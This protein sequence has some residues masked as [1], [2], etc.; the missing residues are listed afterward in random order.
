MWTY[1]GQN[2]LIDSKI[3]NRIAERISNLYFGLKCQALIEIGPWKGA[4]TKLI[5]QISDNFFVIEK[6][7]TLKAFLFEIWNYLEGDVL[8]INVENILKSRNLNSKKT[9]VVWNLPYYITSPILRKF[10][11]NWS[12]NF[13]GWIFMVQKEVGEKIKSDA[14]KKS[15]L[16]WL[17]NY[18][19]DVDYLKTVSAKAF[20]PAPKVDSCLMKLGM[21]NDKCEIK[22]DDLL[23]FLDL[24]APFSRKTLWK[25]SKMVEKKEGI[26]YKIPIDLQKKRLEELEWN[27]LKKILI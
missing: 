20:K 1:L 9:L 14:K 21:R 11:G 16:R 2:F 3:K 15:Y 12:Q 6:D 18:A 26:L 22:W 23:S 17:L 7:S 4:I 24:F 13:A 8:E 5:N 27:D 25:I 10:F 19:Y